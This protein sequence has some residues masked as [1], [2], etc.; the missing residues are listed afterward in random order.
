MVNHLQALIKIDKGIIRSQIKVKINDIAIKEEE[1]LFKL[2][3]D[4]SFTILKLLESA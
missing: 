3:T 1:L 4:S 2:K